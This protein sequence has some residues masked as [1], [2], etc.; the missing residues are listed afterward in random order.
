MCMLKF[1]L[2]M[3]FS[4]EL[5]PVTELSSVIWLAA[6]EG[7]LSRTKINTHIWL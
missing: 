7:Q 1:D 2:N 3:V 4:I 6:R 5:L